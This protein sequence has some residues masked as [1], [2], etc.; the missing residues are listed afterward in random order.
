MV[1]WEFI[2]G[3][4]KAF[5]VEYPELADDS[6]HAP[7]QYENPGPCSNEILGGT[8]IILPDFS[9]EQHL[10]KGTSLHSPTLPGSARTYQRLLTWFALLHR[11]GLP[12]PPSLVGRR[13][14][15]AKKWHLDS[16]QYIGDDGSIYGIGTLNGKQHAFAFTAV[17]E[18]LTL[19]TMTL[20]LCLLAR[21][22]QKGP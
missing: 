5:G 14:R 4:L 20:A 8:T 7:S 22:K 13:R 10:A 19:A 12:S 2:G 15:R 21:R 18:P 1:R 11:K 3:R 16:A 6:D 9:V 17:P